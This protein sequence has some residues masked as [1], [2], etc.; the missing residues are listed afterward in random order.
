MVKDITKELTEFDVE[1]QALEDAINLSYS[2]LASYIKDRTFTAET[3]LETYQQA[4]AIKR[5]EAAK[6]EW[7]VESED[8]DN[9][10][11]DETNK[12]KKS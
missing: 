8:Q 2:A 4:K 7:G 12:K 1:L 5:Y 6:L 10:S 11:T 9:A 3:A